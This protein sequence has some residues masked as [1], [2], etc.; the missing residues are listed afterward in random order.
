MIRFCRGFVLGLGLLM[1]CLSIR[2]Q[3]KH[4]SLVLRGG[5]VID[6]TGS[7]PRPDMIILMRNGKIEAVG[8]DVKIPSEA[9]EIDVTGKFIIPAL[10]DSRM[11]I[12]PTPGNHV[13]RSEVGA[14]QRLES[15]QALLAAGVS[16]TRIIQGDLAEQ[17]VYQRWWEE[18]VL[19][20]PRIV[21]SGP[22]FTAKGGH[23]VEEYSILAGAA[24]D[25]ELRQ[26]TSE[27]QARDYAREV[28]HAGV[29]A[30][31]INADRGPTSA[32]KDR[33]QKPLL[34]ILVREAHGHDLPVFF[35]VG[36]NQEVLD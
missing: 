26:T 17:Q 31:E 13:M 16:T 6:G 4:S 15:L 35:E 25:R 23:P 12:G 21:S 8:K 32:K 33:L 30:F 28:A 7:S 5:T 9:L 34:E 10:I 3:D 27:D 20:S 24:R 18:D 22:V 11:R 19:V 1:A 2:A 36:W 29:N 14:E